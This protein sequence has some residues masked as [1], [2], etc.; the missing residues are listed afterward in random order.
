MALRHVSRTQLMLSTLGMLGLTCLALVTLQ[1]RSGGRTDVLAQLQKP[2]SV[3][4][5]RVG[6]GPVNT[7]VAVAGYTVALRTASNHAARPQLV[8]LRLSRPSG[9]LDG[10]RVT[11]SYSMPSM[12]M[13]SVLSTTLPASGG[14]VYRARV[15]AL[16][17][18]GDWLV[19]LRI[20]PAHGRALLV[21]VTDRMP[22]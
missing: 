8:T 2:A 4:A 15:T 20:T 9:P 1:P 11:V 17:M 22:R 18:P 3:P 16:E 12:N 5:V 21:A 13:P 10:A 6:P 19:S 7:T 14:G